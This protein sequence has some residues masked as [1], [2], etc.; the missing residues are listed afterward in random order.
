MM[1]GY[2]INKTQYQFFAKQLSQAINRVKK[3]KSCEWIVAQHRLGKIAYGEWVYTEQDRRDIIDLVKSQ[4][5]VD[6]LYDAYPEKT[7]RVT[8]ANTFNDEKP[9][10]L[11]VSHDFVLVNSLNTLQ[12]NHTNILLSELQSLGLYLDANS[13]TSIEHRCIVLVE[14]LS[15]MANLASLNFSPEHDFLKNALWLYRGDIKAQ[16]TTSMAYQFFRR[17]KDS[18]QLVCFADFDPKGIEITL[19]SGAEYFIAPTV[20]SIK[21]FHANGADIDY[22]KQDSARTYIAKYQSGSLKILQLY[23][24]MSAQRKTIKQEHMLAK[25]LTLSVSKLN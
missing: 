22:F 8:R 6:L 17:F 25:A 20:E 1:P 12:I 4:L 11:A 7:A 24:L 3:N 23:S 10:T 13:V 16:Q 9:H 18:H 5:H 15:V 21:T 14:N 2:I 19:T